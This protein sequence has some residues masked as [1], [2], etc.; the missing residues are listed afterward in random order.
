M[1]SERNLKPIAELAKARP[2]GDR[3]RYMAGCR[4]HECRGANTAY[5]RQ[6]AAARAAGQWN[7]LVP[8][9]RAREHMAALSLEGVGRRSVGSV[10]G[11]ADTI[12]SAIISG[13]KRQIRASTEKAILAVTADAKADR[14]LVDAG[15]TWKLIEELLADGYT[16]GFLAISM[17][18]KTAALQLRKDTITVRSAYEVSRLYRRFRKVDAAPYFEMVS[19]LREEGYRVAVIERR[20]AEVAQLRGIEF[21]RLEF[22]AKRIRA[23]VAYLI[24]VAHQKMME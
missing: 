19:Q 15:P 14:A 21:D 10:S 11:I 8:A 9:Q 3:I 2:H 5:E 17:G 13:K 24:E 18:R 20:I 6:R 16:K 7:G 22:D 23:D 4:C 1:L 12:L